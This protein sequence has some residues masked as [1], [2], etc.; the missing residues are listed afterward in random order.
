MIEWL[1]RKAPWLFDD[2][3]PVWLTIVASIL[4]AGITY[5]AVPYFTRQSQ[6]ED[7]RSG[8][9]VATTR[10]LN[11]E[12]ISL[13]QTMRKFD[14]ALLNN[15]LN[16]AKGLREKA[17]DDL[18]KLQWRLVDLQV[19]LTSEEDEQ[20]VTSLSNSL[21]R[22]RLALNAPNDSKFRPNV[23]LRMRELAQATRNVLGQL[24][25]KSAIQG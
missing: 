22:L 7:V 4:A 20:Y 14:S 10:L 25:R 16:E 3:M 2:R 23:Q 6:Y 24:Y 1:K 18:L 8:H 12:I 13:S 17:L 15:E 5:V 11:E 21:D 9:L 19:I